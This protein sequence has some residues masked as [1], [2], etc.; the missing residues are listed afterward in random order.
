MDTKVVKFFN[1]LAFVTLI[2]TLFVSLFF[3]VPYIPV[4][5]VAGKGFLISIGVTLTILFWLLSCFSRGSFIVPKDRLIIFA[6]IVPIVFLL[7]SIFSYSPYVS[8]FGSGFEVG[9]FGGMM[10]MSLIFFMSAIYFQ[11]EKRIWRFISMLLLGALI[12]LIFQILYLFIDINQFLPK[13]LR[14]L[15]SGNLI[16]SWNDLALFLGLIVLVSILTLEFLDTGIIFKIF[17]YFLLFTSLIFIIIINMP[18]VWILLGLLSIIIFVYSVSLQHAGVQVVHGSNDK[19]KFPVIALSVIIVCAVF[20]IGNNSIR[21]LVNRY[22]DIS[23]TDVRPSLSATFGVARHAL[24]RNPLI[25]TGPNTFIIDWALWQPKDIVNTVFWNVNFTTGFSLLSTFIVT[26]GL[27]GFTALLLFLI[28]LFIRGVQSFRVAIR[29]T[30]SNYFIFTT[31]TIL[32]YTWISI[33]FYTPNIL[34]LMLAFTSSGMLIGILVYKQVIDVSEF[35]FLTDP[36]KSFFSILGLVAMMIITISVTYLYAEKF[37][38]IIFFA[39]S[40]DVNGNKIEDIVKSENLTLNAISLDHN[41]AYYRSLSQIYITEIGAIVQDKS[42]SADTIK[43]GLQKL[44]NSAQS[45]ALLAVN[46]NKKQYLNQMN[47]GNIYSALSSLGI[48]GSYE[49]AVKAYDEALLL[50]PNRPSILLA[51]AQLEF[52]NK[53]NEEAKKFTNQAISIKNDYVEAMLFLAQ[54]DSREGNLSEAIRQAESTASKSPNNPEV[55]FMIG[56]YRY[57]NSDYTG[58]VSAFENAVILNPD[59][60]DARY[61]LGQSYQKVG[62]IGD[63]LIQYKIIKSFMPDNQVIESAINSLSKSSTPIIEPPKETLPLPTIKPIKKKLPLKT[64]K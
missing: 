28:I 36:R 57:N 10:I 11:T 39:K 46:Q 13:L 24:A 41:D 23:N 38:S 15:V 29:D 54:I 63:A 31:L 49:N 3:F 62:R 64:K 55:F 30:L 16:G 50:S 2:T 34:M 53:N 44:I 7:S 42:L 12:V 58:A 45:S 5:L 22:V 56:S 21:S 17:Y 9:T 18:M 19:R 52:S 25:G 51:R 6:F 48:S 37:T 8:F 4:T 59:Y 47:L 60:L 27:L 33:I 35:S 1:K 61:L 40:L 14:G 26:T 43:S 20:F 32:T